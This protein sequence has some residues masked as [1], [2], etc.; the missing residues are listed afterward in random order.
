MSSGLFG[1]TVTSANNYVKVW[2]VP[3]TGIVFAV[4][5]VLAVNTSHSAANVKIYISNSDTPGLGDLVDISELAGDGG[6]L[7]LSCHCLSPGEKIVVWSDNSEVVVRVEGTSEA[8][9]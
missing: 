8:E 6:K 2:E 4:P 9:V 3:A 5:S 7:T 1:K